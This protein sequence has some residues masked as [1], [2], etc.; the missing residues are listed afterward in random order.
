MGGGIVPNLLPGG[1]V[2]FL[3]GVLVPFRGW[4]LSLFVWGGLL[5]LI[6]GFFWCTGNSCQ[7]AQTPRFWC[8]AQWPTQK[9]GLKHQAGS[10][11]PLEKAPTCAFFWFVSSHLGPISVEAISTVLLRWKCRHAKCMLPVSETPGTRG[12]C[13]AK[14]VSVHV[15]QTALIAHLGRNVTTNGPSG[16]EVAP[17]NRS[18]P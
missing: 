15:S 13:C 3:G 10:R 18:T 5:S 8:L 17:E 12:R 6:W 11:G 16:Q 1:H 4:G 9:Q 14:L 7:D 2:V